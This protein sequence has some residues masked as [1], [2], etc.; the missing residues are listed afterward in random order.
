MF[1]ALKSLPRSLLQQLITGKIIEEV[2]PSNRKSFRLPPIIPIVL[3]NGKQAWT[4]SRQFANEDMFGTELL[5]FEYLLIDAARYTEE[6][7]LS[8]SNTVGSIFLLDQTED[9]EQLLNRLGKNKP[10]LQQFIATR[11]ITPENAHDAP[12]SALRPS[13]SCPSSF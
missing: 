9:Q 8:L 6:E 13:R 2:A 4:A 1:L 3:Y 10:S 7:L 11:S 5:D 12:E